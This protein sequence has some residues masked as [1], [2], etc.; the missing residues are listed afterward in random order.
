MRDN[1]GKL[2]TYKYINTFKNWMNENTSGIIIITLRDNQKTTEIT[3]NSLSSI[4]ETFLSPVGSLYKNLFPIQDYNLDDM[5]QYLGN[6]FTKP[7]DIIDFELTN[8]KDEISLSWHLTPKEKEKVS[9][10]IYTKK[11]QQSLKRLTMLLK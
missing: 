9:R 6:D 5:L 8:S 10:S 4:T 11:N 1:F 7:I 2:T 3:D